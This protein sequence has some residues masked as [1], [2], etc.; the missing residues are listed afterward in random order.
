[1]RHDH[2]VL[3][4]RMLRMKAAIFRAVLVCAC[5]KGQREKPGKRETNGASQNAIVRMHRWGKRLM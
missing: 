5:D 3:T 4:Y 2:A 1:L